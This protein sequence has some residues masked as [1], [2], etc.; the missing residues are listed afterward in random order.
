MT[1]TET[2]LD[3]AAVVAALGLAADLAIAEYH[4]ANAN[5]VGWA[6]AVDRVLDRAGYETLG[7]SGAGYDLEFETS[8]LAAIALGGRVYVIERD[9]ATGRA[10][11][12]DRGPVVYCEDCDGC[13]LCQNDTTAERA[14]GVAEIGPRPPSAPHLADLLR[15]VW[16]LAHDEE[17]AG[18]IS[19]PLWLDIN[20]ALVADDRA[21]GRP[22]CDDGYHRLAD[23]DLPAAGEM[24]SAAMTALMVAAIEAG[25]ELDQGALIQPM[26]N[27]ETAAEMFLGV[28]TR[29]YG[30][31]R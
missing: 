22:T 27:L 15:Q 26:R 29:T 1:R 24:V 9:A 14:A 12:S 4:R 25:R 11:W 17:I 31:G 10:V 19:F 8:A 6:D 20:R 18:H 16:Q 2:I 21:C 28:V 30:R 5:G 7:V 13:D 3:H 23:T